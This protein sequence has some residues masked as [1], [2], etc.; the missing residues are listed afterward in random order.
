VGHVLTRHSHTNT[1]PLAKKKTTHPHVHVLLVNMQFS[2]PEQLRVWCGEFRA[3]AEKVYA[4][5]PHC[6]SYEVRA[7][8]SLTHSPHVHTYIHTHMHTYTHT[9]TYTHI[10]THTHTY[11]HILTHTHTHTHSHSLT[12]SLTHHSQIC[13]DVEDRTKL[14]IYERYA[15][16]QHLDG[17][18]QATLRAHKAA[19]KNTVEP[20]TVSL[21]H[22]TESNIGHMD[23]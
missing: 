10:L 7:T 6:L 5:E 9:H 19:F 2:S 21:T 14:I 15:T 18:H 17:P 11:S 23:R 8:S 12:H 22:Y 16:R 20:V 3:L 4:N 13:Y 1:T